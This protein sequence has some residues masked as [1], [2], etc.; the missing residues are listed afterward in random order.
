MKL[1][2]KLEKV[3]ETD[4][5]ERMT[6]SYTFVPLKDAYRKSVK[7]VISGDNAPTVA[8]NLE[9]PQGQGDTIEIDFSPKQSQEKLVKK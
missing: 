4:T 7:L 9:L 5:S 3:V 1:E 2:C 6:W 8:S